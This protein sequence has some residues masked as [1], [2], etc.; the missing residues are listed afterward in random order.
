MLG[1]KKTSNKI[2]MIGNILTPFASLAMYFLIV[3]R[4]FPFLGNETIISGGEVV[5]TEKFIKFAAPFFLYAI[6]VFIAFA[7]FNYFHLR[8]KEQLEQ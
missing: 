7:I 4:L 1:L 8:K 5:S 2:V 3:N 6:P